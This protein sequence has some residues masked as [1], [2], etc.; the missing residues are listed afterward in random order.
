VQFFANDRPLQ[1]CAPCML[2]LDVR[3]QYKDDRFLHSGWECSLRL[4]N[5]D[6][7]QPIIVKAVS[8]NGQESLLYVGNIA[9][10]EPR[11]VVDL[12]FW[13]RPGELLVNGWAV[14][15]SGAGSPVEVQV[16]VEGMLRQK[17]LPFIRRPDLQQH[18]HD[19]RFLYAGWE[20]S[21]HLPNEDSSQIMVV[22]TIS[23]SGEESLLY[24]GSI[25]GLVRQADPNSDDGPVRLNNLRAELDQRLEYIRYLEGEITRKDA[26]LADLETQVRRWPWQRW[27]V[28]KE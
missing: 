21:L 17:C 26:A 1:Q 5:Y 11:G 13:T 27:R 20:C 23:M 22:R 3:D 12:C 16:F 28:S 4:A 8:P 2:R 19:E 14:D 10:L 25:A 9:S 6:S 15:A 18:F 24:T 7:A